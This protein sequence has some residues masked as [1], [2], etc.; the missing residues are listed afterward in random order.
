ML[1]RNELLDWCRSLNLSEDAYTVFWTSYELP[2]PA[3]R[4]T[5]VDA[6]MLAGTYTKQEY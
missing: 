1:D 6:A 3:R 2:I 4:S 5:K